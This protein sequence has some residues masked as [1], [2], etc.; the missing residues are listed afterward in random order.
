MR[1]ER[2]QISKPEQRLAAGMSRSLPM[3]LGW[4]TARLGKPC[5]GRRPN[6]ESPEGVRSLLSGVLCVSGEE[7]GGPGA[8]DQLEKKAS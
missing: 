8:G 2:R 6:K 7:S 5:P 4:D 3:D 1:T